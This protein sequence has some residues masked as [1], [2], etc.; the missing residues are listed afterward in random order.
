MRPI[1]IPS[2]SA[3]PRPRLPS[4]GQSAQSSGSSSCS[5][6][7]NSLSFSST[8]HHPAISTR[9]F[10]ET[11][12][13][14]QS[15]SSQK[16]KQTPTLF[17]PFNSSYCPVA[18]LREASG[19]AVHTHGPPFPTASS[20]LS[21][22]PCGSRPRGLQPRLLGSPLRDVARFRL[23]VLICLLA[24]LDAVGHTLLLARLS[25]P[26]CWFS[27]KLSSVSSPA[28][29]DGLRHLAGRWMLALCI[30]SSRTLTCLHPVLSARGISS[31]HA[32]ADGSQEY[33]SGPGSQQGSSLALQGIFGII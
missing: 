11:L 18:P 7:A 1:P 9:T 31:T 30:T 24:A 32:D 33:I 14:L 20:F 26:G 28:S 22:G 29:F 12:K 21:P 25:P 15:L 2:S 3:S 19:R 5:S 8:F 17:W 13:M 10:P 27:S 4:S 16:H 6:P 23:R